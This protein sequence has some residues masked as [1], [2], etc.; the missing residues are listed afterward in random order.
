MLVAEL[1]GSLGPH[2]SNREEWTDPEPPAG[3]DAPARLGPP[4]EEPTGMR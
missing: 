3:D 4:V 1:S 2:G